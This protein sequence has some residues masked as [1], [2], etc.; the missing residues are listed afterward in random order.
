MRKVNVDAFSTDSGVMLEAL[1]ARL[2]A[3][4]GEMTLEEVAKAI[5]CNKISV[6]RYETGQQVPNAAYLLKL[7]DVSKRSACWLLTG[8]HSD[9]TALTIKEQ[10]YIALAGVI[11]SVLESIL[12]KRNLRLSPE[13]SGKVFSF[14]FN[15]AIQMAHEGY[16]TFQVDNLYEDFSQKIE[17]EIEQLIGIISENVFV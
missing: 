13:S 1:G 12:Q 17:K 14:I 16:S 9:E 3:A 4:R 7:A 8:I 5:G 10:Y 6:S 15:I 11:S 2:R